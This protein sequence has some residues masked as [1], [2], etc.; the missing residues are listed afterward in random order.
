MNKYFEQ[1]IQFLL[2]YYGRQLRTGRQM[3][4]LCSPPLQDRVSVCVGGTSET[5]Q[6]VGTVGGV[7]PG[8]R[9]PFPRQVGFL[10]RYV[11]WREGLCKGHTRMETHRKN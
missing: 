8:P 11:G 9:F 7:V 4:L 6:V 10:N 5:G 2:H 3:P 1:T